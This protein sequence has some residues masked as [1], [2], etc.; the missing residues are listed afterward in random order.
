MVCTLFRVYCL[1]SIRQQS[2][3]ITENNRSFFSEVE[4]FLKSESNGMSSEEVLILQ[5]DNGTM[6][7]LICVF[8]SQKLHGR[9]SYTHDNSRTKYQQI[10]IGILS[11][12]IYSAHHEDDDNKIILTKPSVGG[13]MCNR[14][15]ARM[16]S[17]MLCCNASV[18]FSLS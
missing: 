18:A 17:L 4:R 2:Q 15:F 9:N 3:G 13:D 5:W 1:S 7:H 14:V 12:V 8:I 10:P 16:L 11:V 6:G